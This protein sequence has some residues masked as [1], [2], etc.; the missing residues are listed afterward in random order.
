MLH[1]MGVVVRN[2]KLAAAAGAVALAEGG[3]GSPELKARRA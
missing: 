2:G 3:E 1:D